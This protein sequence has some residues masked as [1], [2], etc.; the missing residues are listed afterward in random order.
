MIYYD[1]EERWLIKWF[2]MKGLMIYHERFN[3]SAGSTDTVYGTKL[4]PFQK[5]YNLWNKKWDIS[6]TTQG[7]D[8]TLHNISEHQRTDFCQV[9]LTVT[10][11]V[12]WQQ[13]YYVWTSH[14]NFYCNNRKEKQN[15][16][17]VIYLISNQILSTW[18]QQNNTYDD[19]LGWRYH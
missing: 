17:S 15:F 9:L 11:T 2:T 4:A 6:R 12:P 10:K 16:C 8:E 5:N 19:Q 7:E 18:E 13:S 14:P 3:F 1:I